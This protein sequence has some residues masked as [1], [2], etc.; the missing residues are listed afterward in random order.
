MASGCSDDQDS[1]QQ[2]GHGHAAAEGHIRPGGQGGDTEKGR[3]CRKEAAGHGPEIGCGPVPQ[4]GH[5]N[6]DL[7]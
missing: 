7:P 1:S 3:R 2:I 6:A 4:R 5:G